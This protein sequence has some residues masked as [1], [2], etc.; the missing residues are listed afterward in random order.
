MNAVCIASLLQRKGDKQAG[1]K[2]SKS[3]SAPYATA[4]LMFFTIVITIV[5]MS[6]PH[7]TTNA[8]TSPASGGSGSVITDTTN[9]PTN[10]IAAPLPLT[11]E[12][13][14]LSPIAMS[15]ASGTSNNAHVSNDD[16]IHV[17]IHHDVAPAAPVPMTAAT[18]AG[19]AT[20]VMVQPV[21][22]VASLATVTSSTKLMATPTVDIPHPE[23][24]TWIIGRIWFTWYVTCSHSEPINQMVVHR[25][26][27]VVAW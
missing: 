16:T 4:C 5:T 17:T 23:E 6:S 10:I 14:P 19:A 22:P 25:W 1:C 15:N 9:N 2:R 8:T 7:T 24:S 20:T 13:L 26:C 12:P 27:N 11:L 21:V 18:P 3:I